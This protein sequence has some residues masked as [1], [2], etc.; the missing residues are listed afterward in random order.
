[1]HF[2]IIG[3]ILLSPFFFLGVINRSKAIWRGEGARRYY[4]RITISSGSCAKAK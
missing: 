4:K 1:M 3:L 2:L